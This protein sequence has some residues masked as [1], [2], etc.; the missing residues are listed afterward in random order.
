M[1]KKIIIGLILAL[2]VVGGWVAWSFYQRIFQDNIRLTEGSFSLYIPTGANYTTVRDSLNKHNLLRD[3]Q[4]FHWLAQLKNYPQAIRPGHYVLHHQM[5]NNELVNTLRGGMQTPVKVTFNNIRRREKLAGVVA[6]QIE[7]DSSQIVQLMNDPEFT[8]NL[9]LTPESIKII[10]IPNTY[11]LYW[12][13]SAEAFIRRMKKEYDR[14]WEG[15]RKQKAE[16]IGLSPLEVSTLASI[17]QAEQGRHDDE[18]PIIAGIYMNRLERGMRLESCPTLI[19]VVG[20]YSIQRVLTKFKDYESPYNTYM[21]AGL[22]PA[23][24]NYPEISSIDAVLNYEES[25]YLF[26]AAK[27]DFSGYHNF[28]KTL[29]QHNIY[30][31]RYQRAL[32]RRG[33]ME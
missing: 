22:P 18:K 9:G 26:M 32:D 8:N 7:A 14:F 10:F 6:R 16:A 15:E 19:Y 24:I 1:A 3:K 20:D 5:T 21:N 13:T 31:R 29:R 28:S 2:V 25:D 4:A 23:P 11:E 17:V 30:A 33:I 27:A 12:N